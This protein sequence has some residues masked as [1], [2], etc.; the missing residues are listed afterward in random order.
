M[1]ICI[2]SNEAISA[3][4]WGRYMVEVAAGMR[5]HGL[6]PVMVT[7]K[8]DVD[9]RLADVEHHPILSPPLEGRFSTPR[10][11]RHVSKLRTVLETCDVVHNVVELY[12]PLVA[13]A[14]P[15]GIPFIQS[16]FGTWAI[17]PLE[18]R[19]QRLL[20]APA[21]QRA[22]HV[23]SISA[24]TRDWIQ[25]LIDLPQITVLPGGVHPEKFQAPLDMDFPDWAHDNP[26]ILSVGAL[27]PRRGMHVV[28]E[29]LALMDNPNVHYA[30]AGR[31]TEMTAYAQRLKDRIVELGLSERVHFLGQLPPYGE[32]AAWY[33]RADVFAGVSINAGSSFEGLGFVFLEA[34]AAG[35][36]AVATFN[37]GAEE[38]VVNGQ[39][40]IL[41]PQENPQATADALTQLLTDDGLRQRMG[42]AAPAHAERLSWKNLVRQVV[43]V[44][45]A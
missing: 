24:F 40:G 1:R 21:F 23:L 14:R 8:A 19:W 38:A 22:D 3:A 36:P 29:A 30:I 9:P 31:H 12:A 27:K 42:A 16:V 13:R 34:A 5:D 28:V 39:T 6:E 26:V 33:Q 44:Y 15:Q 41:V 20:F 25:R 32:L 18:N 2:I 43:Q 37:C 4:G 11:L 45:Q 10:S 35:T 17:R 7:A